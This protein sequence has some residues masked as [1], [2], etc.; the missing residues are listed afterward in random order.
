[1]ADAS[2]SRFQAILCI[3]SL[4][5]VVVSGTI[6]GNFLV[7][8]GRNCVKMVKASSVSFACSFSALSLSL[9]L[10]LSRLFLFS[11][12]LSLSLCCFCV[13]SCLCRNCVKMVKAS[14]VSQSCFPLLALHHQVSLSLSPPLSLSFPQLSLSPSLRISLLS[15]CAPLSP[16]QR[17]P[18]CL[19]GL[20]S[21]PCGLIQG[22]ITALNVVTSENG[23]FI[24]GTDD[25]KVMT[26]AAK[27]AH[28]V[29]RCGI[30]GAV[31]QLRS[32]AYQVTRWGL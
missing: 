10:S 8:D 4:N 12:C 27:H 15:L 16:C 28:Q 29:T 14:S 22:A 2:R 9:S 25:G 13:S 31:H 30:Q 19:S 32:A 6:T 23:G 3:A 11:R 18:A 21:V 24:S 1:M 17:P 20:M 26:A 7:W 5:N